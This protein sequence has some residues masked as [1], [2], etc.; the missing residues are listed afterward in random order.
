MVDLF[1]T[2]LGHG[3]GGFLDTVLSPQTI[4]DIESGAV[5][6]F[7]TNTFIESGDSTKALVGISNFLSSIIP[8]TTGEAST[9]NQTTANLTSRI[10]E[11]FTVREQ[12]IAKIN[13]NF[14]NFAISKDVSN[15]QPKATPQTITESLKFG[16]TDLQAALGGSGL[17]IGII[18]VG[19][20]LL[21]K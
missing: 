20:I 5:Q 14:R 18:V 2:T 6:S 3:T 15:E 17:V 4:S 21:K 12:D 9:I 11:I 16:L 7:G 13:E 19:F 8:F 1:G 10:N